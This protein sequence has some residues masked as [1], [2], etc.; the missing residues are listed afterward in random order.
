ML[1]S[2]IVARHYKRSGLSYNGFALYAIFKKITRDDGTISQGFKS[3]I[4]RVKSFS[5]L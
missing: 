1:Y 2:T 4:I 3:N 5:S